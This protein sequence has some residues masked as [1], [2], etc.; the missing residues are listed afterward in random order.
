M[1]TW[2]SWSSARALLAGVT[3]V[4]VGLAPAPAPAT[5]R[6]ELAYTVY[7]GP[8]PALDVT[9]D[10]EAG[11]MSSKHYR[12][13][14][15]VAPQAWIAWALPWQARSEAE[16]RQLSDG[17]LRPEEYQASARWGVRVRKTSLSFTAGG[18]HVAIDPPNDTEG[19]EPVPSERV[20]DSLDPVSAVLSLLMAVAEG[21]GCP[22]RLPVFDGRR[23]FDLT[24]EALAD[25][26]MPPSHASVYAGPVTACRLHF[27]SLAGGWRDGERARFWQTDQPGAER[28]PIDLWLARLHEN[29]PPVPVYV[30]GGSMLGWVTVYL[31]SY[32]FAPAPDAP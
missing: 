4:V 5:E 26:V 15:T 7:F 30:T 28:P 14:A 2:V 8:F 22:P 1:A 24:T 18:V 19:R 21:R 27:R 13:E 32:A 6:Q 10:I 31:S 12:V 9:T 17:T 16:G 11:L 25:T 20:A 3:F 23:R 29:E